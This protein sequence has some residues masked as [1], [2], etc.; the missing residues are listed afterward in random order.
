MT[1]HEIRALVGT[2]G[3]IRSRG[4][5]V[6]WIEH[7][8]H[9]LLSVVD[10]LVALDFGRKLIEGEPKAVMASPE[11]PGGLSRSR[12]S[13]EERGGLVTLLSLD[14]VSGFYDDFQALFDVSLD[15]DEGELV[16]IIGANG[17]ASRR[18]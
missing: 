10:R 18:C 12:R 6:V 17:Q 4:I 13:G 3:E 7:V 1:E 14:R 11:V 8:V 2:I 5:A 15:V 16:A 9:A